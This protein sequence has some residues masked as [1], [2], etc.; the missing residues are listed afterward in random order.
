MQYN[1]TVNSFSRVN[2]GAFVDIGVHQ[3]GLVHISQLSDKFIRDP[4]EVVAPGDHVKVKVMEINLPKNQIALT[5][6]LTER[7]QAREFSNQNYK[8]TKP[9]FNQNSPQKN[10]QRKPNKSEP[11]PKE[12]FNNA[13]SSLAGLKISNKK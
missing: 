7:S 11:K 2:F 5:M 9:T 3:D 4:S 12:I 10:N 6:K 1:W 13:F 8:T